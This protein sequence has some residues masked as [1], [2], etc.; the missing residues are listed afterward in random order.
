MTRYADSNCLHPLIGV[1][2]Y[3]L[4]DSNTRSAQA[5]R[6]RHIAFEK[7]RVVLKLDFVARTADLVLPI[8]F[9]HRALLIDLQRGADSGPLCLASP[10]HGIAYRLDV[11]IW[12]HRLGTLAHDASPSPNLF[13]AESGQTL[14]TMCCGQQHQGLE[15]CKPQRPSV[16]S[17]EAVPIHNRSHNTGLGIRTEPGGCFRFPKMIY[18]PRVNRI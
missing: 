7:C 13:S 16:W 9:S 3:T 12:Q 14:E 8:A 1:S 6:S 5:W 2:K 10:A 4:A 15:P 18:K 11:K 17:L